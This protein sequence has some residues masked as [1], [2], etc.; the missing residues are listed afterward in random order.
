MLRTGLRHGLDLQQSDLYI[1]TLFYDG[2][3]V[4]IG[5]NIGV[6]LAVRFPVEDPGLGAPVRT[7]KLSSADDELC[8]HNGDVTN[9]GISHD[10]KV[11][12]DSR[13]DDQKT[14]RMQSDQ[15]N[16]KDENT[17]LDGQSLQ[18]HAPANDSYQIKTSICSNE[19]KN[20]NFSASDTPLNKETTFDYLDNS[21]STIAESGTHAEKSAA[22]KTC[23]CSLA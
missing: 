5:T 16:A 9:G 12:Y 14:N 13:A 10:E 22:K 6:V 4:W 18:Y 15:I 17:R 23:E 21:E 19:A 2:S 3:L 20:G 1:T 11:K 8:F 7:S